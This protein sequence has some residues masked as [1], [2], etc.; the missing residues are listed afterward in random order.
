[1]IWQFCSGWY[2][3]LYLETCRKFTPIEWS[4]FRLLVGLVSEGQIPKLRRAHDRSY[5]PFLVQNQRD[6]Q[7]PVVLFSSG[8]G[9][10][11]I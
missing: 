9:L 7:K 2:G 8:F 11:A 4:F 6:H 1:M 5:H 3:K 10:D